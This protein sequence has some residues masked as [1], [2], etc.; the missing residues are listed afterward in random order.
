V[1]LQQ[2]Q[3]QKEGTRFLQRFVEGGLTS[4]VLLLGNDGVGRRFSVLCAIREAFCVGTRKP[5][6]E[7]PSCYQILRK[8]H[9]DVFV[10][11]AGEKDIG[12]EEVRTIIAEARNYPT[13]ASIRCFVI[14]GAD[15][16]TVAAA[17]AFLKTLEEPPARARFFLLAE[18]PEH[19]LPTIRS[20]C[21]GIRYTTLPEEFVLSELHRYEPDAAKA[22]VYARMGEGSVGTA[23]RYWGSG[24]VAL[25][26]QV[27][28]VLQLALG[29]DLPSLFALVDTMDQDLVLALKF[30][31]QILHDVLIVRVDPM[32]VIN[33][34]RVEGIN[35]MGSK[36]TVQV[37]SKLAQKVRALQAQYRTTRLHLPFHF[38]T[39]IIESFI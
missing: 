27:L 3:H 34:D 19:V 6:C 2:V 7:C 1:M 39:I 20:R 13:A 21:G 35:A 26:D 24:R 36:A 29:R 10:H 14:D 12:I 38:K 17:N 22:L 8:V 18:S 28:R 5:D 30:L 32:R 37:W 33:V 11:E 15:R 4:P 23:I 31:G 25:R 9:T 16:F